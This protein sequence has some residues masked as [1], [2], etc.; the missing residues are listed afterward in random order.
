[1]ER[2]RAIIIKDGKIA[3]ME[4]NKKGRHFFAFPGGGMEKGETPKECCEREV[5]EEFG[6]KVQAKNMVYQIVQN[7]TKQGFFVCDWLD[8]QIH[9]TD[10]EEYTKKD[11]NVSGTYD[12][13]LFDLNKLKNMPVKP[14]EVRDE[15]LKDLEM[16]TDFLFDTK[17][18]EVENM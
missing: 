11:V 13:G 6:I 10:A 7:G 8:G 1:M 16:G 3:L 5:L 18:I 14:Q 9:K 12:P 4:R 15:L 2:Y 17:T